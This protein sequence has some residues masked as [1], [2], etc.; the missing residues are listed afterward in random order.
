MVT[1]LTI[2]VFVTLLVKSVGQG[3]ALEAKCCR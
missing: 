3:L 1:N 2:V